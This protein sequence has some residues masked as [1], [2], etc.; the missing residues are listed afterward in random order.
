MRLHATV[1]AL[2]ALVVTG[3]APAV[4]Q[5]AGMGNLTYT[6]AELEKPIANFGGTGAG[7]FPSGPPGSNTALILRNVLIIMSSFDSGVP[8]GAFH[9]FDIT[10]PRAPRRLKTLSGTP[11]TARLRELHAMPVALLDGKD[12]LVFPTTAG[13]QFFDFTDPINP[14]PVGSLAL[15]GANGGDYDNAAWMVSWTWPYVF[16]AGTGNGVW[17]VDATNPAQPT[18]VRRVTTGEMGNFR[19]GPA[20]PAGNYLVVANMDQ[21]PTHISVIDVG[22]PTAPFLLT[23]GTVPT[24]L[25]SLVVVG[26]RIYG[27]GTNG[28]Y[29]FARWSPTAITGMAQTKSGSDRGGYCTYQSGFAICGQSSEGYK[30][31]DTR[32]EGSITQVGHGTDPAGVGGD[33]DFATIMGNLV[34][35]GN[36]HGTGAALIPHQMAPD[37]VAP[38]VMKI[39]PNDQDVRQP[40]STRVTVFFSE[41]IDI[42][43]INSA[44]LIVRK[45]G[46][47]AVDGV[48]SK[49]SFNALSFGARQPLEAN[50]TYEVVVPSGGLKDLVGNPLMTAAVARFSTGT[51]IMATGAGGAVGG[52]GGRGAGGAGMASGTGGAGTGGT[53]GTGGGTM[54]IGTGGAPAVAGTGGSSPVGGG[55]TGSGGSGAASASNGKG[56]CACDVSGGSASIGMLS[57]MAGAIVVSR[58]RRRR[59]RPT[60]T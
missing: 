13:I 1:F 7:A 48:Y 45:V 30:K 24:N 3:A 59:Q 2:T 46:G 53:L 36:D 51:S 47:A 18:L 19:I 23:T 8:P 55:E 32:N 6:A 17:I 26:D 25:Y 35:L 52:A 16:V 27:P 9:I 42:A 10:N 50:T 41:D 22:V 5:A 43:S 40:L 56:G 34:Y 29:T 58:A 44:N 11:E 20:Y 12:I 49:S 28:D 21:T 39:Y 54:V 37:S 57:L 4:V 38:E 14:I 60:Q 31:W 15:T 33:F